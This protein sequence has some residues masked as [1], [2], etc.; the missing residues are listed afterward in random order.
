M[1]LTAHAHGGRT[2][3]RMGVLLAFPS[4]LIVF[5]IIMIPIQ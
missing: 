1:S 4:S 3:R 2:G 5:F